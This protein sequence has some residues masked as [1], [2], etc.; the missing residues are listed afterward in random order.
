MK[1]RNKKGQFA[2]NET[3]NIV[4]VIVTVF[5]V[6][7]IAFFAKEQAIRHNMVLVEQA[8]AEIHTPDKHC[9]TTGQGTGKI[10]SYCADTEDNLLEAINMKWEEPKK[11]LTGKEA[12]KQFVRDES[13]RQGYNN[14]ELAIRIIECESKF[15]PNAR[16]AKNNNPSWSVDRGI[17]QYNS[18]WYSWVT[19]ECAYNAECAIKTFISQLKKGKAHQWVCHNLVK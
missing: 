17:V 3:K 14:P 13:L 15:N 6:I 4:A 16:N 5:I 2:R 9:I 1:N 12:L 18:H 11:E 10:T 7:S 8:K 19:D